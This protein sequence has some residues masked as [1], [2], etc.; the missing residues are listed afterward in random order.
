[1][2]P[3]TD[4]QRQRRAENERRRYKHRRLAAFREALSEL[5]ADVDTTALRQLSACARKAGMGQTTLIRSA[6]HA[7]DARSQ[8]VTSTTLTR[9]PFVSHEGA[10]QTEL[11]ELA[12]LR[13]QAELAAEASRSEAQS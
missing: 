11:L 4:L 5:P 3:R 10:Q 8:P 12:A 2:A 13:S 7:S 6:E 9:A 1:M